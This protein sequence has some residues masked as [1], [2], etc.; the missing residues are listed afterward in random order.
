MATQRTKQS[1]LHDHLATADTQ[2]VKLISWWVDN[3][4]CPACRTPK[5]S[6]K[7]SKNTSQP[8]K[9][10]V[11]K[12]AASTKPAAARQL[13]AEGEDK[14]Q[15]P[16]TSAETTQSQA[17]PKAKSKAKPATKPST[18][19]VTKPLAKPRRKATKKE[20]A[21]ATHQDIREHF[22]VRK[23]TRVP[24]EQQKVKPGHVH[25]LMQLMPGW[26]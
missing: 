9:H 8:S 12:A 23:S 24:L 26:C 14:Q 20:Q 7:V 15:S 2:C 21:A 17:P 1:V 5:Q 13:A 16:S 25:S 18:K 6:G 4:C 11:T 10:V 19:P 3:L 22:P